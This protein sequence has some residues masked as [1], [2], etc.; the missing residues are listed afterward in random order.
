MWKQ[1]PSRLRRQETT[2]NLVILP[3]YSLYFFLK[4]MLEVSE[5]QSYM[6][7]EYCLKE[8]SP[9]TNML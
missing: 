4:N 7:S 5:H 3:P 1:F 6:I 8:I 9:T 2:E